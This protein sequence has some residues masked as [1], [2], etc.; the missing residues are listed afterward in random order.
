MV[1]HPRYIKLKVAELSASIKKLG[2]KNI[3]TKVSS[4]T[5]EGASRI[6]KTFTSTTIAA[7]CNSENRFEDLK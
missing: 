5:D 7:V 3:I 6:L 1:L 4:N 2:Y